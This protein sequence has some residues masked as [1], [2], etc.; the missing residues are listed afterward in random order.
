MPPMAFFR[1]IGPLY[2][3]RTET[4][5]WEHG[6]LTTEQH[7]N[8]TGAVHGGVLATLM[9]HALSIVAWEAAGRCRASTVSLD[10]QFATAVRPGSFII[11]R[12]T[13][14]RAGKSLIF[15]T[16]LIVGDGRDVVS[17]SGIWSIVRPSIPG[18][19]PLPGQAAGP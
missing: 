11:A 8:G 6:L 13:V 9:D 2:A 7:D 4:G 19:A 1:S 10:L 18:A 17:G 16:G 15:L 12:G 14:V 5:A 3:R